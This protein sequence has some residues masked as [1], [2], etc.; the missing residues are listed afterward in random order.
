MALDLPYNEY[1]FS[2]ITGITKYQGDFNSDDDDVDGSDLA[3]LIDSG[4]LSVDFFAKNHGITN[5]H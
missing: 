5:N 3:L 4:G 2:L 1:P